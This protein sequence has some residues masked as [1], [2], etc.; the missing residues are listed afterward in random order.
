MALRHRHVERLDRIAADDVHHVEQLRQPQEIL[1]VGHAAGPPSAG[2]V[3]AVGRAAH[4]RKGK[5]AVA[6]RHRPPGIARRNGE[7]RRHRRQHP[8]DERPVEPHPHA[9]GEHLGPVLPAQL[10]HRVRLDGDAGILQDRQRGL[11]DG[12][13]GI[14]RQDRHWRERIDRLAP[15]HLPVADP[16]LPRAGPVSVASLP[17]CRCLAVRTGHGPLPSAP[18]GASMPACG[19]RRDRT[20]ARRDAAPSAVRR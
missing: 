3:G 19:C 8:V 10:P 18:D 1:V 17:R 5:V 11:V 12:L 15:R 9:V 2:K 6:E 13:D 16:R 20:A 4:R 14:R 7:P